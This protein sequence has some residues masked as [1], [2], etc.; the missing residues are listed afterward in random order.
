MIQIQWESR[1]LD[2]QPVI[3]KALGPNVRIKIEQAKAG[4]T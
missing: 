3:D 2:N 4:A 1:T